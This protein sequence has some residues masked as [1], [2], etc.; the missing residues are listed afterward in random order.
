MESIPQTDRQTDRSCVALSQSG[1]AR[2]TALRQRCGGEQKCWRGWNT[3]CWLCWKQC[4]C[5]PFLRP[6]WQCWSHWLSGSPWTEGLKWGWTGTR[7]PWRRHHE[8][9]QHLLQ[10]WNRE[11]KILDQQT[12]AGQD[13]LERRKRRQTRLVDAKKPF[14]TDRNEKHF[15]GALVWKGSKHHSRQRGMWQEEQ[16]LIEK[17]KIIS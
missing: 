1:A 13:E 16:S 4:N 2:C 12:E 10:S 11:I 17:S 5:L 7:F 14:K 3:Y 8:T 6:G 9:E 15:I